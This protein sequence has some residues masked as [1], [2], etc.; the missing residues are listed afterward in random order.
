MGFTVAQR[1]AEAE[2]SGKQ[3]T[4]REMGAVLVVVNFGAQ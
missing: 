1:T 3:G 2:P 4:C